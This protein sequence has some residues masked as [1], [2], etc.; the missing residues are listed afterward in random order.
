[1]ITIKELLP[2]GIEVIKKDLTESILYPF[3]N[4]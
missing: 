4:K 2:E 3:K 1:M